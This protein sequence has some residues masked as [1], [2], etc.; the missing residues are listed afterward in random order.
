MLW[1]RQ[2]QLL[3]PGDLQVIP[4]NLTTP[5]AGHQV[6]TA[7]AAYGQATSV[8]DKGQLQHPLR[9]PAGLPSPQRPGDLHL[10]CLDGAGLVLPFWGFI[11]QQ[12]PDTVDLNT[13]QQG[14]CL[15]PQHSPGAA[16]L[17]ALQLPWGKGGHICPHCLVMTCTCPYHVPPVSVPMAVTLGG[18]VHPQPPSLTAGSPCWAPHTKGR[19]FATPGLGMAVYVTVERAPWG[20]GH[21]HSVILQTQD[22]AGPRLTPA[23]FLAGHPHSL[24]L[25]VTSTKGRR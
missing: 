7:R 15:G 4:F 3:V 1:E 23:A 6:C 14:L 11:C 20:H 2:S 13:G 22:Q 5:G 19:A 16:L 18:C 25:A 17:T 21:G 12:D 24:M 8:R 10:S 9:V